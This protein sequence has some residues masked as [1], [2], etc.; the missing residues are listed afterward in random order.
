MT[1]LG[2]LNIK[3]AMLSQY[4]YLSQYWRA[5]GE[6][7]FVGFGWTNLLA[8]GQGGGGVGVGIGLDSEGR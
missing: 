6:A 3:K 1:D 8:R 2:L 5:S 7:T 4:M